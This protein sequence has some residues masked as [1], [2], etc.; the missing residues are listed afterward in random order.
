M[1]QWQ[2]YANPEP[3]YHFKTMA[4]INLVPAQDQH[5]GVLVNV[6]GRL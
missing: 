3:D 6:I 4:M 5:V 2:Q 1:K